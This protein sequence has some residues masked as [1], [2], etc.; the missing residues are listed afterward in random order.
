MKAA[1]LVAIAALA[2]CAVAPAAA[3]NVTDVDILNFA[4]NLEYLEGEFY[5]YAAFGTPLP[6]ELRGGG[7]ASTGGKAAV[8]NTGNIKRIAT[9]IANDEV[10]HVKFLRMALGDAAVP[11]PELNIGTAFSDAADA[12][13][14]TTLSPRFTP[15]LAQTND[16]I[17]LHGAFIFEDVGVTAYQGAAAL[18]ANKDYLS[19]AAGILAVEAYHAGTV[20]A[21][22]YTKAGTKI[23]PYGAKVSTIVNAISKLRGSV[24]GGKDQ[25]IV[26]SSTAA[27]I[28]PTDANSI[29]FGRTTTEVLAIVYLGGSGKGGFFPAGLNGNIK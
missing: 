26:T 19:A 9:E 25:G 3:Q 4:L 21:L 13:L 22:L 8:F 7:P 17:F 28:V 18:I 15:Y 27:N 14:N 10:N 24:G 20:R 2:F 12:A 11:I 1:F 6:A 29:T 23:A 16:L 5:H